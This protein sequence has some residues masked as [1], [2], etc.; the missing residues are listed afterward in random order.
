M[1]CVLQLPSL[2]LTKDFQWGSNLVTEKAIPGHS[3]IY[4][5]TKL[6][7]IWRCTWDHCLA[8]ESN[9]HQGSISQQRASH[10]SLKWP[11]ISENPWCQTHGQDFQ[12]VQQKKHLHII[13]DS[14]PCL[15]MGM[16]FFWS[17]HTR[18]ARH[19]ISCYFAVTQAFSPMARKVCSSAIRFNLY[20][21]APNGVS[22]NFSFLGNLLIPKALQVH[23]NN[24]LSRL[25]WKLLS[26]THNCSSPWTPSWVEFIWASQLK[27]INDHYRV[28]KGLIMLQLHHRP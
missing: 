14:P 27:Q 13:S 23:W 3:K 26:L 22:W 25:L 15:T 19:T 11:A 6:W 12:F 9:D 24:F 18:H 21:N 1:A 8:G 28:P 7:L 4:F 17:G 16:V 10:S 20:Y 2:N 5:S